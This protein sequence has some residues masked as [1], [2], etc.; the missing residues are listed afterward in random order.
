MSKLNITRNI[1]FEKEELNRFQDFLINDTIASIFLDNTTKWGIVRTVFDAPSP[2]FLVESGSNLGTIKIN[3]LSKAV[4]SDRLLI[5][6]KSIDNIAVPANGA[7]Y[8]VKISHQYSNLEEGE[9]SI[10]ID[11][12]VTGV[13]TKFSEVLRG[14]STET[15]V[16]IK[17]YKPSGVLLNNQIYEVVSLNQSS[18][19]IQILLS[20]STFQEESGLKYIVIGSTPIFES[21]TS[22]Q[23][24]GLYFYDSCKI[25]LIIE[26]SLNEAPITGYIEEKHFYIARV[27]NIG[28]V[29]EIEDK[30]SEFWTFNIEG[31]SDKLDK[32]LNLSDLPDKSKARANLGVM[33]NDEVNS[34][35]FDSGWKEMSRGSSLAATPFSIKI[36]RVGKMCI[37][38][39]RFKTGSSSPSVGMLIARIPYSYIA[40]TLENESPQIK[41]FPIYFSCG[42]EL[43]SSH[44]SNRGLFGIIPAPIP[45]TPTDADLYIDLKVEKTS[46]DVQNTDLVVNFSFF[47]N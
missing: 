40:N 21:I 20:G 47:I 33:S 6:Q 46:G 18:P 30:R 27:R 13:N 36:R 9:C 22:Q 12:V 26:E 7:Y 5:Y 25:E 8:W 16:K 41:T 15:P 35:L 4:D 2:D 37:V 11:G 24:N 44:E 19:D 28:G 34:L 14:Y 31:M 42:T 43:D 10:N 3:N 1:F 32:N 45:G 23:E 39:G 38:Q 17:F 29:V